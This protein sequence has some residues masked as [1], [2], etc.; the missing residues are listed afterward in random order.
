L[1]PAVGLQPLEVRTTASATV[2][3]IAAG[4]P[5]GWLAA[6]RSRV[7]VLV[8][9]HAATAASGMVIAI[10]LLVVATDSHSVHQAA[11]RKCQGG[12]HGVPKLR[13]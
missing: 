6:A 8:L 10:Q 5:A 9:S 13:W 11:A 3:A 7:R 1:R 2:L 12:R 4:A